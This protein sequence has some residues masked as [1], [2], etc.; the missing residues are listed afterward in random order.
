MIPQFGAR[1]QADRSKTRP[2]TLSGTKHHKNSKEPCVDDNLIKKHFTKK[3]KTTTLSTVVH[4][5]FG[6]NK[7]TNR[8]HNHKHLFFFFY[9]LVVALKRFLQVR[10]SKQCDCEAP[11]KTLSVS[12]I[13]F[14]T[15][16]SS[17][18]SHV[19]AVWDCVSSVSS[20]LS[21]KHSDG[22]VNSGDWNRQN[23]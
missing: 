21:N 16:H 5:G 3:W 23:S 7:I 9:C 17:Q 22:D 1:G 11:P 13:F 14:T 6:G 2:E 20:I 12:V 19:L 8:L 18:H 4:D 15:V 10:L